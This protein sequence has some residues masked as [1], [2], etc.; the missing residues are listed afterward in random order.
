MHHLAGSSEFWGDWMLAESHHKHGLALLVELANLASLA[1]LAIVSL[2]RLVLS[3][4][5]NS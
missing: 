2:A 3:H 1:S 5:F 4:P